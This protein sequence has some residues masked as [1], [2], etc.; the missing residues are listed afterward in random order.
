[1]P[2]PGNRLGL[3]LACVLV[4]AASAYA[5]EGAP[6]GFWRSANDCFMAI[7]VLSADGNAQAIYQSGE[8]EDKAAWT[9]D[10]TTLKITSP[11]FPQDEFTGRLE[12]E[13]LAA[14]YVWHDL[15]RDQLNR[16]ACVF[17]RFMPIQ[18]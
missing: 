1:M 3:S 4:G 18:L 9:W 12:G 14:D 5:A 8:R 7:F 13:R 11:M 16:Q 6:V 2:G 10:G 15:D 17:E